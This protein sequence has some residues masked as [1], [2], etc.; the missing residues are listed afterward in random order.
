MFLN[1]TTCFWTIFILILLSACRTHSYCLII[2]FYLV[3]TS[4]LKYSINFE[5]PYLNWFFFIKLSNRKKIKWGRRVVAE[6]FFVNWLFNDVKSFFVVVFLVKA[7]FWLRRGV[8]CTRCAAICC[9]YLRE[10]RI[11][12]WKVCWI[13]WKLSKQPFLSYWV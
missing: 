12:F 8:K 9:W 13:S 2:T 7:R 1:Y 5:F 11:Q 6:H 10:K 3:R 4:S